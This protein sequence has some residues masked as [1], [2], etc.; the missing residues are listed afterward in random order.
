MGAFLK[1][2]DDLIM[3]VKNLSVEQFLLRDAMLAR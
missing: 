3:T 1:L 2:Q